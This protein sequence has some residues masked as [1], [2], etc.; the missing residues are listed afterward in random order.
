MVFVRQVYDGRV[1]KVNAHR[2]PRAP[3]NLAHGL[4]CRQGKRKSFD[5]YAAGF[6]NAT[7]VSSQLE[8]LAWTRLP[9]LC[10]GGAFRSVPVYS[11][12]S[13]IDRS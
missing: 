10:M 8:L 9:Y 5:V 3:L 13:Y 7:L 11:E 2:P 12:L 6:V 4:R 1:G